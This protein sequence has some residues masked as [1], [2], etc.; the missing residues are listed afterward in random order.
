MARNYFNT[1]NPSNRF[2][3][4]L[5]QRAYGTSALG[6]SQGRVANRYSNRMLGRMTSAPTRNYQP[7]ASQFRGGMG[8]SRTGSPYLFRGSQQPQFGSQGGAGTGQP[9]SGFGGSGSSNFY[10]QGYRRRNYWQS[11][12]QQPDSGGNGQQQP[13]FISSLQSDLSAALGMPVARTGRMSAGTRRAIKTFQSKF[14]LGGSG[15]LNRQTLRAIRS[16]AS[17]LRFAAPP[18]DY[19]PPQTPDAAPPPPPPP[20]ASAA[21]PDA[22]PDAGP[23][24]DAA[25]P[26]DAAPPDAGASPDAAAPPA[27]PDGDAPQVEFRIKSPGIVTLTRTQALKLDAFPTLATVAMKLPA[28]PGIYVVKLDGAPWYVGIAGDSIRHR[29]A[30]RWKAL[31]DFKLKPA[32]LKGR[33]IVCYTLSPAQTIQVDYRDGSGPYSPRNSL[34][35]VVR[36]VEQHFIQSLKTAGKGNSAQNVITFGDGAWMRMKIAGDGSETFE[37]SIPLSLK[38]P[39]AAR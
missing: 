9:F 16:V 8:V 20:D 39:R 17:R 35:G 10:R 21:P 30:S 29:F 37:S 1:L 38:F 6:R 12:G 19:A 18:P 36:A 25:P 27:P 11:L 3:S 31:R 24:P 33:E 32:D 4:P 28:Q 13:D 14:G 26:A 7:G 15:R 5:Q 22:P 23:A 34:H 2:G